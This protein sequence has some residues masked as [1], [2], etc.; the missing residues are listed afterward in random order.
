M[1]I[2][3]SLLLV[4]QIVQLLNAQELYFPPNTTGEW[5][6]VAP[7]FLG[8]DPEPLE[9]LSQFLEAQNSKAFILLK[10]GK[11]VMERYFDNFSASS[12]WYWASAGKSLTAF[13]VGIAQQ[14]GSLNINDPVSDYLGSGWTS[15]PKDLEDSIKVIHLL[16]MTSGLDDRVSDPDCTAPECLVYRVPAGTR[17][18]YHNAPYTLLNTIV[19]NAVGQP[20]NVYMN[21][22]LFRKC[23]MQGAFLPVENNI[24]M[25]STARSFARFGLLTLAGGTWN[26]EDIIFDKVYMEAMLNTS[27]LLNES[28]G[29]LWWLNG[30]SSY[31]LPILDFVFNG[32]LFPDAPDDLIAALGKD[33]QIIH[34]VPSLGLVLIRMGETPTN[35]GGAVSLGLSND[36]W[37]YLNEAIQGTNNVEVLNLEVRPISVFPNPS[38]NDIHMTGPIGNYQ[39]YDIQGRLMDR[40]EVTNPKEILILP[41]HDYI[42]GIYKIIHQSGHTA[43]FIVR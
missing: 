38:K 22:K 17:W 10:D 18:A 37:K 42:A 12:N 2:L 41:L 28:Y 15:L 7:E 13:V 26:D 29:Y 16:T 5:E 43:S 21:T 11:I 34:V 19:S 35:G 3:I 24:V 36:I 23:G 6:Q 40:V 1:K 30:K 39:I 4:L 31:K 8:W 20:F 32:A 9:D 27:T 25:F 14:E 33:G